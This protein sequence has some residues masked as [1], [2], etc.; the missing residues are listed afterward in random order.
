MYEF[1]DKLLSLF[2]VTWNILCKLASSLFLL[3]F[4]SSSSNIIKIDT[5]HLSSYFSLKGNIQVHRW[6]ITFK[7]VPSQFLFR[8]ILILTIWELSFLLAYYLLFKKKIVIDFKFSQICF[9]F[10]NYLPVVQKSSTRFLK[11]RF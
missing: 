9:L 3:L 1:L 8:F 4:S 6:K 2:Q 10:Q 7:Y 11:P 5:Y